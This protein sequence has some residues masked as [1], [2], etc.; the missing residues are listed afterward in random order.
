LPRCQ[1]E[2][3]SNGHHR[4]PRCTDWLWN[5]HERALRPVSSLPQDG[6]HTDL[7]SACVRRTSSSSWI[8]FAPPS[9]TQAYGTLSSKLLQS[10]PV[11]ADEH[12]AG[13]DP[14]L[15]YSQEPYSLTPC[16]PNLPRHCVP[17]SPAR[18]CAMSLPALSRTIV[19]R[20]QMASLP[21]RVLQ[22]PVPT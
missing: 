1:A 17:S 22:L 20:S 14:G 12:L 2:P 5:R 13:S 18:V 8:M 7:F 15:A 4:P 6:Q 11:P 9:E 3:N 21:R 16:G 10:A 19:S